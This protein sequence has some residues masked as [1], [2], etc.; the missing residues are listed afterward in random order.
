MNQDAVFSMLQ[1]VDLPPGAGDLPVPHYVDCFIR[2]AEDRAEEYDGR[3]GLE[4]FIP[5]DCR[6]AYQV[7]LWLQQTA[8][9]APGAAFLEW[10]SGQ[11]MVT[12]L[13][14]RAGYSAM[15]VEINEELL[16]EARRLAERYDAPARFV[17]GTY[18]KTVAGLKV[19]AADKQAVV[20]VYPWPGEESFFLRLFSATA[21]PGAFLLVNLGPEDI[22]VYRKPEP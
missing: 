7:L 4:R 18:D 20:Y 9:T 8:A 5:S 15:G 2:D 11:G 14:S 17:H 13:A 3:A 1:R 6:Y 12:I 19:F 21:D 16:Q 22:H 10:G